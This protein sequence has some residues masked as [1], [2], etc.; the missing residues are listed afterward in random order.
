MTESRLRWHAPTIKPNPLNDEKKYPSGGEA[1]CLWD[2]NRFF[3]QSTRWPRFRLT[4][5]GDLP[6]AIQRDA[7]GCHQVKI[8]Y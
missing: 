7:Y 6:H 2:S 8:G 4:L 1:P 5:R 3:G